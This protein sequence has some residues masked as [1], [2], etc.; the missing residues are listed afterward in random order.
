MGVGWRCPSARAVNQIHSKVACVIGLFVAA[1]AVGTPL[2]IWPAFGGGGADPA[3]SGRGAKALTRLGA[4]AFALA[5]FGLTGLLVN[6]W[7]NTEPGTALGIASAVGVAAGVLNS[8]VFAW[9]RRTEVSSETPDKALEGAIAR[10][11]LPVSEQH[12]GMIVL[13]VGGPQTRMTASLAGSYDD[14]EIEA[15]AKV[16]VIAVEGGVALVTRL[17]HELEVISSAQA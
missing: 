17:P 3:A 13:D 5:F 16:I 8:I 12:R 2:L 14:G 15:G 9:I 6:R 4:V 11:T 7:T 10:V 1:I